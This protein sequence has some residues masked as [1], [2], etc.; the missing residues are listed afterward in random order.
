MVNQAQPE[1][2]AN[3]ATLSFAWRKRCATAGTSG[4]S[5][6]SHHAAHHRTVRLPLPDDRELEEGSKV[7]TPHQMAAECM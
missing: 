6:G 3:I 7:P 2:V 4:S 5:N 1:R